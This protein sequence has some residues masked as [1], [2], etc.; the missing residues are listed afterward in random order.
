MVDSPGT[1]IRSLADVNR[2]LH[3]PARLIIATILYTVESA[4]FRFLLRETQLTKGN[5]GSHLGK[6]EEAGY[7]SIEK[8]YRGK[9]PQTI[10]R[11]TPEGRAAYRE[12][13]ERLKQAVASLP[14]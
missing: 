11:L 13:R 12:Y 3:E 4:D 14:E 8:T 7:V 5:L 6:L 1:G 9:V 10:C 2:L